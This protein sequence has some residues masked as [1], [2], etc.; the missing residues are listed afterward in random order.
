VE[1]YF[2]FLVDSMEHE[3][4]L[5]QS[6]KQFLKAEFIAR[7]KPEVFQQYQI[8][9][10]DVE[11]RLPN[12]PVKLWFIAP[13]NIQRLFIQHLERSGVKLHAENLF[14]NAITRYI[15]EQWTPEPKEKK[16]INKHNL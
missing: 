5:I 10:I 6:W 2:E 12:K 14:G 15:I 13:V 16:Q 9:N 11:H 7:L 8:V 4:Y 1:G 3:R